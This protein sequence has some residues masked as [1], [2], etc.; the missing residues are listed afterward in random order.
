MMFTQ[1]FQ[2][3]SDTD[4]PQLELVDF[5]F[6]RIKDAIYIV[7]EEGR[8]CYANEAACQTLHY[9]SDE[10]L[11]LRVADIDPNWPARSRPAGWWKEYDTDRGITFETCHITHFGMVIPV[12]VNLTHF[13]HKGRSYSMCVVRDIRERKHIEQLSY[14]REQEFRALVENT[15]DLITRFDPQLNCLY[16]NPATLRHLDFT[17][18]QLC[19]RKLTDL[20]PGA[21][22]AMRIQQLVQQVVDS[23]HSV[24]GELSDE[25][26]RGDQRHV[27]I[28]HIRC[29]PEFDQQGALV[30]ILAVGR[31]ITAIRYAERKLEDSHMQLSLLARQREISREAERKHIAREIHDELGQHLTT[32]RMSLSLMR[33]CF[34]KDNPDMQ[35]QLKRLMLLSDQ[36]IQV[37]RNVS[38]RLRPNVLNMG[39]TPALEWLCDEFNRNYRGECLLK[40][41]EPELTLKDEC[42][43]AAFRVA[44]E[45]LTNVAR[46]AQA[47]KV[48]ISLENHAGDVVLR[49][50]DN[51]KGFDDQINKA[52][53]FGLISMKERGRM[54]G[55]EVVIESAPGSGTLVQLTFP[56]EADA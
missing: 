5:A 35:E 18:E 47:T 34:A 7:N 24:E 29:V 25:N 13:K 8:F 32:I 23:R 44:Q 31:D 10:F 33:M 39:L 14:A 19:G 40:T 9:S 46:H 37:V 3:A 53:A 28:H 55:G 41:A 1:P 27:V 16:A 20:M 4:V 26:G 56:M 48:E 21:K 43:T 54:L 15:P 45:S 11:Q 51:G 2:T 22:C 52:D 12:E 50:Q 38:T 6:S 30:S 49:I 42:V 17:I 36:T